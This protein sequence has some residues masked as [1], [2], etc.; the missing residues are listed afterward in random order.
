MSW[1]YNDIENKSNWVT[2]L[3]KFL[4][5][6]R[7]KVGGQND[8]QKL[9]NDEKKM[10]ND[11]NRKNGDNVKIGKN[12]SGRLGRY[13]NRIEHRIKVLNSWDRDPSIGDLE[14]PARVQKNVNK[15]HH[16]LG[17]WAIVATSYYWQPEF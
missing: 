14:G 5:T 7:K 6:Q 12:K 11:Q 10:T 9:K 8:F 15:G 2:S 17:F 1:H 3:R 4:P 16:V 13:M